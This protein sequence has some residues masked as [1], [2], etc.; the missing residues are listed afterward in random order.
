MMSVND[1]LLVIRIC[2]F[3]GL[4]VAAGIIWFVLLHQ[5]LQN[6]GLLEVR[7]LDVGQGDAIHIQTPDG[8]EL[9]ID[10]GAS[11]AVLR[12]LATSRSFFDRTID[13]VVA[14]HP[15]TDHVAGLVDVLDRYQVE[16]ILVSG[17]EGDSP[18][19]LAFAEASAREGAKLYNAQAG[20]IIQ[21]G[22]STT[23][24]VLSPLGDT[25]KWETNAASVIIQVQYGD[26]GFMLTGDAPQEIE[27]YLVDEYGYVLESEVLKLGHHGSKTSS[28]P[29]FIE[30]VQPKYAVVS[31]GIDN[32][33][34]HPNEEVV[35]RASAAGAQILN[36]ASRGTITFQSDGSGVWVKE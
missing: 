15:D 24:R 30:T 10:G 18:A 7:F 21:L 11:A 6:N 31:A 19:A 29:H 34:G 35:A 28:S 23:V 3:V 33:Y 2:V 27:E 5:P 20:Q 16:T 4:F 12:Q 13:V 32:R 9:L 26:V 22:A 1:R 17:V 8:I 25:S 14:T 36:T